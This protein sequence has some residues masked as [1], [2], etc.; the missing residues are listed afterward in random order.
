M[1]RRRGRRRRARRGIRKS[2]DLQCEIIHADCDEPVECRA[3]DLSLYG[4]WLE[5][6][7]L[8]LPGDHVVI[9]FQPPDWPEHSPI[10]VFAE[11]ARVSIGRRDMDARTTGMG[12]EFTDLSEAQK[13]ALAA[14]LKGLP[15]P[16]PRWRNE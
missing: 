5:T 15:P 7:E 14:C 8:V 6:A 2:V 3:T 10:T 13:E 4:M 12:V 11:V 9:C 1:A 16:L